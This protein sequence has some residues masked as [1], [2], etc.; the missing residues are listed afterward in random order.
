MAQPT[1]IPY[2]DSSEVVPPDE[3]ADIREAVVALR[4]ILARSYE[5]TGHFRGDV[6]VK[7]HGCATGELRVLPNLP[8]ELAQGLFAQERTYPAM[9]RFSN[10][11]GQPQS[12]LIPDGRGLAI[13]VL[14]VDGQR[15]AADDDTAA[16]DFVMVNHPVFFA[17]NVKEFVRFE[18]I[19]AAKPDEKLATINQALTGGD[20]NPLNW[21]WREALTAARIAGQLPTHPASNTYFSMAPIRYGDYVA[22]Y[23]V[24]LAGELS[25]SVLDLVTKLATQPDA[26]RLM[27]AETLR[28]QALLFEFQV[29]LQTAT[30]SMP[31]ED[32]TVP[33]PE[34]ES[35]YRTVAILL[36]PRQEIDTA[37]HQATC[38]QLAFN[39]WHALEAHRP[40]GGINR[41]RREVYPISA[42]WRGQ[43]QRPV[44]DDV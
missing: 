32:A 12:D 6:H 14:A 11:A 18:K 10:A 9:I 13:K 4:T 5:Q 15:S 20:W 3:A 42:A 17:G 2:A 44:A 23:R 21:H 30:D 19:L 37:E 40:L 7:I 28:S 36:L 39:V 43:T 8:A 1:P 29:Q 41:L 31:V 34:S 38:K 22:K 24:R 33:W 16:Q 27:L 25:G 35:P 26:M